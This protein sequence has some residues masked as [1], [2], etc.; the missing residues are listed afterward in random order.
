MLRSFAFAGMCLVEAR[1]IAWR[2][3]PTV[4]IT[5]VQRAQHAWNRSCT[6]QQPTHLSRDSGYVIEGKSASIPELLRYAYIFLTRV[7][8]RVLTDVCTNTA[9]PLLVRMLQNPDAN[10]TNAL[11]SSVHT[12]T[13]RRHTTQRQSLVCSDKM[14]GSFRPASLL[15]MSKCL[16][17][18]W[19]SSF[20]VI[21]LST[22][23]HSKF[24]VL[25]DYLS[26]H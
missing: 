26:L 11:H 2:P 14:D 6:E 15:S 4:L 9:H 21:K 24:S 1:H 18:L 19:L 12:R 17:F 10:T 20:A 5:S 7:T 13:F 22:C 16:V 23:L 3:T 8:F 25:Y